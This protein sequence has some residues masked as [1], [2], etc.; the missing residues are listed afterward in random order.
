MP[1]LQCAGF[2][3]L[4]IICSPLE[5][6]KLCLL[7]MKPF[8]GI[9]VVLCHSILICYCLHFFE[10]KS[11]LLNLKIVMLQ[12]LTTIPLQVV[13]ILWGQ[14]GV[15]ETNFTV[16]ELES[17]P[18]P[19]HP[20]HRFIEVSKYRFFLLSFSRNGL[21]ISKQIIVWVEDNDKSESAHSITTLA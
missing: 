19:F 6:Y 11:M 3:I 20:I 21:R 15:K 1:W 8:E 7:W 12:F 18:P 14:S 4:Y 9:S 17:I 5:I 16:P 13:L 10:K 2:A